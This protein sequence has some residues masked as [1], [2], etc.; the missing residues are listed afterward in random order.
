MHQ[1]P[2]EP[3]VQPDPQGAEQTDGKVVRLM[4]RRRGTIVEITRQGF[5]STEILRVTTQ[6]D[7]GRSAEGREDRRPIRMGR[8]SGEFSSAASPIV[9]DKITVWF[10]LGR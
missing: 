9:S 10:I 5:R 6:R 3:P 4:P 2:N 7:A 1:S 8:V